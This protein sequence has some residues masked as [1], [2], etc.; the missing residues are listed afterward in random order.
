MSRALQPPTL[1][2]TLLPLARATYN[3]VQDR[4]IRTYKRPEREQ[5]QIGAHKA[6]VKA[7]AKVLGCSERDA[8]TF[9]AWY[10]V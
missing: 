5:A 9:L 3:K 8:D 2:Q 1:P 7:V 4:K 6:A 10:G